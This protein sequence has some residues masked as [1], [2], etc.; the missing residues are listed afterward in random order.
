MT[1][2]DGRTP[3]LVEYL[4]AMAAAA[5]R[6][7]KEEAVDGGRAAC[8]A[9]LLAT[10]EY[11]H[12]VSSTEHLGAPLYRLAMALDD[13]EAGR[14]MPSMLQGATASRPGRKAPQNNICVQRG[15][16]AGVLD[17]LIVSR[18]F[19]DNL[20]AARWTAQRVARLPT[21]T[22]SRAQ[23]NAATVLKWREEASAG[24]EDQDLDKTAF[25]GFRDTI[26]NLPPDQRLAAAGK[27]LESVSW[28]G[29]PAPRG[30]SGNRGV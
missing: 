25:V 7:S 17:A 12:A 23:S 20:R 15:A 16:I 8:A 1:D 26:L 10:N 4:E 6:F 28:L 11:L 13:L 2:E 21:L 29:H 22:R 19:G 27:A 3:A 24:V 5:D 9:A 14:Q 18:L 30:N